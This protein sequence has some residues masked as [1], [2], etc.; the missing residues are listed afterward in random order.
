MK[1]EKIDRIFSVDN[2]L[3][4]WCV[5]HAAAPQPLYIG[6]DV[7]RIFFSCRD[8]S[9]RSSIAYIDYD[10]ARMRCLTDYPQRVLAPGELGL[11]DD[12]GCFMGSI[13]Q[14]DR[15]CNYLYYQGWHLTRP[16][17]QMNF[18][19]LA[20]GSVEPCRFERYARV[21]VLDRTEETPFS[22]SMP[23]VL[24]EGGRYRMWFGSNK[25]WSGARPLDIWIRAADS[26][27]GIHWTVSPQIC[28][29][30]NGTDEYSL[31]VSTVI[32]EDGIYK[33]FYSYRGE[34]YR[35]GY[36]ESEDGYTWERQDASMI[37]DPSPS[38]WDSE[39]IEYPAVFDHKGERYML[40][41]GNGYGKSGFGLAHF[42]KC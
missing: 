26:D 33:M 36:A 1:W 11:F 25:R 20:I 15:G 18:I 6:G 34:A 39:M 17:P 38:G 7:Y 24:K 30:N 9:N 28:I 22:V 16:A 10:I 13:V 29:D 2:K 42:I 3:S 23:I 27:D 35:I 12:C 21:P 40:Y 32:R 5:S 8:Q 19:G 41:C 14:A 4:D 37:I 31:A